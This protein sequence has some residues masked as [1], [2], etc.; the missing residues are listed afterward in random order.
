MTTTLHYG[1]PY[2]LEGLKVLVVGWGRSGQAA[3]KLCL[4]E[5]ASVKAT[6][7]RESDAPADPALA[8]VELVLG[9]HEVEDFRQAD[10]IVVSPGV[11]SGIPELRA[12]GE[13]GVPILG[14]L[15]LAASFFTGTPVVALTGTNGKSTTTALLG[16]LFTA[17]GQKVFVGGNLGRPASEATL[18]GQRFDAIVLEVSSFQLETVRH[19]HPRVAVVLNLTP[20]HLDRHGDMEGYAAAK[21]RIFERCS[22]EAGDALVLNGDDA[23]TAAMAEAAPC[24]THLFV[25][26]AGRPA[27]ASIEEGRVVFQAGDGAVE[28]YRLENPALRGP[29]NEANAAAA[30]LAGRLMGLRPGAIELGLQRF[31]G[32]PHRLESVRTH[33][34]V[35]WVNDSKATNVDSAVT[36]LSAFAAGVI[37]VAGGRGKGA[38]YAPLAAAGRG[39]LKAVLGIGEEGPALVEALREVTHGPAE[40]VG[41]LEAAVER[42]RE[43]SGAGETVLLSPAC[44]S[45]DQFPNY[46]VRGQRFRELV[47]ALP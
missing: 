16:E 44:A 26:G 8:A 29:H 25:H 43:L 23:H 24:A 28:R 9:R 12:A 17:A 2:A 36:G 7:A 33:G 15:E 4:R 22:A 37:L 39:R 13:A 18:C 3:A 40:I 27:S 41:T 21:A 11:P 14:E 6:D 32:L 20:D 5:G 10:L 38:S 47:E 1:P 42:A 30:V 31:G 34:G 19:F 45:Y 46:E 35:E